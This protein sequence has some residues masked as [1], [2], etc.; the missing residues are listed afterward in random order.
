MTS[1]KL[2]LAFMIAT[3]TLS[4]TSVLAQS[5]GPRY[6]PSTE[7]TIQG[8]VENVEQTTGKAGWPGVHLSV[9]SDGET[10]NVHLGPADFIS[11]QQ[12]S[13]S[14]GDA[15]E[16]VG[17]RITYNSKPAIIAREI[18]KDG[19]RLVLRDAHGFPA[20]SGGRRRQY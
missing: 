4:V 8:T 6:D 18:T 2:I 15:V 12:F 9:K 16:V 17:S 20:W 1:T 11:G 3:L 10:L 13:F 5:K 7:T 14:K 19:K